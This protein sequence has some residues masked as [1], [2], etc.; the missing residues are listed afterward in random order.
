MLQDKLSF[1][2]R[3][4][5]KAY[6]RGVVLSGVSA[7]A[8]CWF[9]KGITDSWASELKVLDCLGILEGICCPHYDGEA[10]R[11]PSVENFLKKNQ[12]NESLCIED[13]SAV[14]YHGG[15]VKTAISFYKDKNAYNV[16]YENSLIETPLKKIQI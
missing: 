14:H 3:L 4:L 13:G 1:V 10:D 8:I 11:R 6:N 7:G 16:K 9:E 5:K 12:I 15:T 2:D